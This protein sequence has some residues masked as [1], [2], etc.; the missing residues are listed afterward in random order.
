MKLNLDR[1]DLFDKEK[2]KRSM[3]KNEEIEEINII[4]KEKAD[5]ELQK[6]EILDLD[7]KIKMDNGLLCTSEA[8]QQSLL[9]MKES[10]ERELSSKFQNK[11]FNSQNPTKHKNKNWFKLHFKTCNMKLENHPPE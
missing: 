9:K 7:R 8:T 6:Q 2:I 10:F 4:Q 3:V 11:G 5:L 1:G